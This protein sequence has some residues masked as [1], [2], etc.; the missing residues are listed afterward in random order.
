[1]L[2]ANRHSDRRIIGTQT[3]VP[4]PQMD[5]CLSGGQFIQIYMYHLSVSYIVAIHSLQLN[6]L[7]V[8]I[9]DHC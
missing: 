8:S 3:N 4:G 2:Q 5:Y 6:D 9:T 7:N 1:M